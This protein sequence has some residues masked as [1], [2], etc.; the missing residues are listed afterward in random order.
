[1]PYLDSL[2]GVFVRNGYYSAG[3]GKLFH[4]AHNGTTEFPDGRWD[5][6]W[7]K[8]QAFEQKFMNSSTTPD[9]NFPEEEFRDH[10]ISTYAIDKLRELNSKSKQSGRPF[11]VSIGF[12]QPHTQYH[13]PRKYFDMYKGSAFLQNILKTNSSKYSFPVGAPRM[14]YRCCDR[15]KFWPMVDE[16][17]KKSTKILPSFDRFY[18]KMKFPSQ[19]VMELQWGYLGGVTFLDAMVCVLI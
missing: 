4:H 13:L 12:K 5:G 2:F 3:I 18:G 17:R 9:D 15:F 7:Y 16:G 11:M 8:Y 14:N 1:M 6:Y 19:A 10:I